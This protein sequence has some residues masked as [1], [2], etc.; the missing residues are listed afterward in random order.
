MIITHVRHGRTQRDAENLQRHLLRTDENAAVVVTQF[1]GLAAKDLDGALDAMRR[2]AP[3]ATAAAFHHISMSPRGN[4]S[5]DVLRHHADTV[6][7]ELGADA[8][9]HPHALVIHNKQSLAGR[10]ELH[11]HLIIS[12]WG[13][14]GRAIRDSWLRLRLERIAREIEFDRGEKLTP[15]RHDAALAR[16]LHTQGRHDVAAA[17]EGLQGEERPR[18]AISPTRRQQVKRRGAD[19]VQIRAVVSS[20]WASAADATVFLTTLA[21]SD[22]KVLNGKKDGVFVLVTNGGVEIGA[23]D[24]IVK[25][26]RADV[27][28]FM[29]NKGAGPASTAVAKPR[30]TIADEG[31]RLDDNKSTT[32]PG[33]TAGE[34]RGEPVGRTPRHPNRDHGST[35]ATHPASRPS[36]SKSAQPSPRAQPSR[37]RIILEQSA[38]RAIQRGLGIAAISAEV[39]S[40]LAARRLDE[41][42]RLSSAARRRIAFLAEPIPKSRYL[43]LA[44]E[45]LA[46]AKTDLANAS[47]RSDELFRALSQLKEREPK[48]VL[49]FIAWLTGQLRKYRN[50][51]SLAEHALFSQ[52]EMESNCSALESSA[53]SV[54][55]LREENERLENIAEKGRRARSSTVAERVLVNAQMAIQMLVGDRRLAALPLDELLER[56]EVELAQQLERASRKEMA[57]SRD[58]RAPRPR[59]R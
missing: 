11:A 55:R 32:P 35:E 10:G 9:E 37:R 52:R 46:K 39:E 24:R 22:L 14:D 44:E 17:L 30:N 42:R 31:N 57:A 3:H 21:G 45:K 13:L 26:R 38:V 41:L 33:S 34:R 47:A 53:V 18:S 54:L 43:A 40:R 28:A 25:A 7:R 6:L 1:V 48:G 8:R 36:G 29:E 49:R 2:L 51:R 20:A 58:Y 56:G 59:M 15:G 19:D 27:R 16:A 4:S 5:Q 23:L 12:H 50:T